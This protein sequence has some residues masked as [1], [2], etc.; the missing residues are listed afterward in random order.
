MV[1]Y[2]KYLRGLKKS[3]PPVDFNQLYRQIER[4]AARRSF[5]VAQLAIPLLMISAL[6]LVALPA[7]NYFSAA[8][9]DRGDLLSFVIQDEGDGM[10]M[11]GFIFGN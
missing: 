10:E 3:A 11:E 4:K 5:L 8:T 7:V 6:F 2:D 9:N 1:S